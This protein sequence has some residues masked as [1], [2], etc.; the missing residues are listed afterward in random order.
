[1]PV[2]RAFFIF[3]MVNTIQIVV[4]LVT[5]YCNR[6]LVA[7]FSR[8]LSITSI[9]SCYR[10]IFSAAGRQQKRPVRLPWREPDRPWPGGAGLRLALRHRVD[11]AQRGH[12][13][14]A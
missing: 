4:I 8:N 6:A 9:T 11:H 5:R 2:T 12:V 3:C 1:M 14:D 7:H 10:G 13:D